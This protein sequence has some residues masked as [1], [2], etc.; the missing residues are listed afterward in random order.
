MAKT[1]QEVTYEELL[2]DWQDAV[3]R[4]VGARNP[5]LTT[6][7]SFGGDPQLLRASLEYARSRG[8]DVRIAAESDGT[9]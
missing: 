2:S 4:A 5:L 3:D 9:F 7:D 1:T 8:V 6:L